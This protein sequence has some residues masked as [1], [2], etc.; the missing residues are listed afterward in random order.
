[1]NPI[2][3]WILGILSIVLLGTVLD[4]LLANSRMSKYIR[5]IFAAVTILVIVL[6]LPS[7]IQNGI[8]FENNFIIQNDFDLDS[9]F[10]DFANRAKLRSL[11]VGVERQLESDGI[12][13]VKITIDGSVEGMEINVERVT[14]NLTNVVIDSSLGHINRNELI[15][16]KISEYLQIEKGRIVINE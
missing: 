9:G 8:N 10:L 6:P 4:L 15:I 11:S 2:L 13:G 3:G 7:L 16:N 12:R 5:S 1:M 14:A